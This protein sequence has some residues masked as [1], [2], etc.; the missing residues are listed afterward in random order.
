[1]PFY[2]VFSLAQTAIPNW[3]K[4]ILTEADFKS[5]CKDKDIS[6]AYIKIAYLDQDCRGLYIKYRKQPFIVLDPDLTG[7][8]KLWVQWHEV[9]HYLLHESRRKF[10]ADSFMHKLEIEA[11]LIAAVAM[12]PLKIV[13]TASVEEIKSTYKYPTKVVL[14]RKLFYD[15]FRL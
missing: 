4:E 3:N 2:H 15:S 5:F 1:M 7:A 13:Q 6:V 11:N 12:I 14:L 8:D 10:R 9:G